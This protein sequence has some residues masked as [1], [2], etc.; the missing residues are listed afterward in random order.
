MKKSKFVMTAIAATL[1]AT[2]CGGALVACQD[3]NEPID[4]P[5]GIYQITFDANGGS[6]AEGVSTKIATVDGALASLPAQDPTRDDYT[7]NGYT[8]NADG[9]GGE[10]K[11]GTAFTADATVYA[12]WKVIEEENPPAPPPATEYTVTFDL[13][14]GSF[15]EGAPTTYTT[16]NGKLAAV[17]SDPTL[18]DHTFKGYSLTEGGTT[19]TRVQLAAV[20]FDKDTTV[21]AVWEENGK[22]PIEPIDPVDPDEGEYSYSVGGVEYK[23][24]KYERKEPDAD[25]RLYEYQAQG[26]ELV[27]GDVVTFNFKGDD[28]AAED[29]SIEFWV[30]DEGLNACNGIEAVKGVKNASVKAVNSGTFDIYV[31]WYADNGGSFVLCMSDGTA[32]GVT[33]PNGGPKPEVKHEFYLYGIVG[34]EDK[35]TTD[36]GYKFESATPDAG[37][38][39]QYSVTV[40]LTEG[41]RV[42]VFRSDDGAGD[43]GWAYNNY[44]KSDWEYGKYEAYAD[45]NDDKNFVIKQTGKFTFYLKIY[46]N[47]G[48]NPEFADDGIEDG[49]SIWVKYEEIKH[50]VGISTITFDA[51]EG[52][53]E[54]ATAQTDKYGMLAE[55]PVPTAPEGKEFDGW[56]TEPDGGVKVTVYKVYSEN[57]TLYAQY[58]SG[59]E[60]LNPVIGATNGTT[61]INM[62]DNTANKP[63][64]PAHLMYEYMS[65]KVSLTEGDEISFTVDGD[66]LTEFH[67]ENCHGVTRVGSKFTVNETG[68]F[69][70]YVRF[71]STDPETGAAPCWVIEINDGKIDELTDGAYYLVGSMS[72]W[73]KPSKAHE[74]VN[75]SVTVMLAENT[76]FKIA[77]VKDGKT[78]WKATTYKFS[79]ISVGAAYVSAGKDGNII[80]KNTGTYTITLADGKISITSEDV[81]LPEVEVPAYSA[82]VTFKDGVKAVLAFDM[83]SWGDADT[84][85][86]Y[87]WGAGDN[88]FA[89]AWPGIKLSSEGTVEVDASTIDA[90]DFSIIVQFKQTENGVVKEKKSEDYVNASVENGGMYKL[91]IGDWVYGQDG[92]FKLVVA[93]MK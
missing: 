68:E 90:S 60:N 44:E 86:I 64:T 82:T 40:T 48:G 66:A 92:V 55:L 50:E 70:I 83:P 84:A 54:T 23:M 85:Y 89:V 59:D 81:E 26:V 62:T 24:T 9:S 61:P 47:G 16:A 8:V 12:Q 45:G 75:G 41:D 28:N 58:K 39:L 46:D 32:S 21:H 36:T 30:S 15:A 42:K 73:H 53:L 11:V 3:S 10:V 38:W 35:W 43:K 22:E 78:D 1:A 87:I 74:L 20:V 79:D 77:T 37:V 14:G 63:A 52:T 27:A 34:G 91:S 80:I 4:T 19:M 71:Y 5:S 31:K 18:A 29:G 6:Y 93:S 13:H 56:Y 65:G 2:A 88:N 17:P 49:D 25:T 67:T 33:D 57:T 76:E 7:F 51:G 69:D 72:D